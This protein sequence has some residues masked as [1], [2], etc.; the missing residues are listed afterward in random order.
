VD[1]LTGRLTRR[2]QYD[3]QI[4]RERF[5]KL[6]GALNTLSP[7][8]TLLRGYAIAQKEDR[9]VLKDAGQVAIGERVQLRLASGIL[10]C[11]VKD[12]EETIK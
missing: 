3:L 2:W 1:L 5:E 6:A 4:K 8:A 9:T 11:E 12:K 7:L 10:G